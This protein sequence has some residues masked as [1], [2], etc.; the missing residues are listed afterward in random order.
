VAMNYPS[1]VKY[2]NAVRSGGIL[3]LNSDLIS[4]TPSREDLK[5]VRIPANTL[6][7]ELGNDK[8]LNMVMLGAMVAVTDIVSEKGLSKALATIFGDKKKS[9]IDVNRAALAKGSEFVSSIG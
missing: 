5:I 7:H 3:F 1:M 9:L 6:A 2:Q 4:E 8:A